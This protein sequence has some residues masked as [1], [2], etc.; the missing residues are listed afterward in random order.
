MAQ[1]LAEVGR[2]VDGDDVAAVL[3]RF[4]RR[5]VATVAD[6]SEAVIVVNSADGPEAV[7][8]TGSDEQDEATESALLAAMLEVAG[9]VSQVLTY[10][11]PHR[12][13]DTMTDPRWP[14]FSQAALAAGYRSTVWLP[15]PTSN[16]LGA[17]IG[18]FSAKPNAF[19]ALSYD[20]VLLFTLHAG[21][22]FDNVQ[23]FTDSRSLI[24]QL[25]TALGTRTVI[26]QAQGIVMRRYGVSADIAQVILARG[27]QNSNTKLRIVAGD[28]VKA[29]EQGSLVTAL[30]RYGLGSGPADAGDEPVGSY[31]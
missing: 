11:E 23:L 28:L 29:Q 7:A 10:A 6:C 22:A 14:R 8:R 18:L 4:G 20:L 9:P 21:V 2:L 5:V 13:R 15:L 12:I 16:D 24:E 30:R 25:Q 17:A 27:S 19:D 31:A 1:E 26:G 3:E